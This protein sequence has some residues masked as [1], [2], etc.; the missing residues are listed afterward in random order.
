MFDLTLVLVVLAQLDGLSHSIETSPPRSRCCTLRKQIFLPGS[1]SSSSSISFRATSIPLLLLPPPSRNFTITNR[2]EYEHRPCWS[3]LNETQ[4][5]SKAHSVNFTLQ[6]TDPE[7][8]TMSN[9]L[10]RLGKLLPLGRNKPVGYDL[11]GTF[12]TGRRDMVP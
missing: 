7:P 9:L 5:D 11:D 6:N 12:P 1:S 8:I 10:K 2:L 3:W 4:S